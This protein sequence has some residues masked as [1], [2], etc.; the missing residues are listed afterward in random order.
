MKFSCDKS[1]ICEAI[2]NVSK[3]VAVK[4]TMP[5]LEGIKI[6][7]SDNILEL[8][9]YDLEMGMRTQ[10]EVKSDDSGEYVINSRLFSEI[11]KR[12]PDGELLFLIDENLNVRISCG[13]TEYDISAY[14]AD[15]YPDLPTMENEK[16][17]DIPQ[18][19]MKSMINQSVFAVS[20]MD[21]KPVLTGELFD[22]ENGVFNLVAID[23]Y[24]LAIRT[25]KLDCEDKFY[26]VVPSKAMNEVARL[27]KD[28]DEAVCNVFVSDKHIMFDINGYYFFSRLLEGE[29]HNYRISLF[30][31]FKT[32]VIV[33]TRD[34]LDCLERCSLLISEK[35][36]SAIKCK[37]DTSELFIDCKT[38]IG[39]VSDEISIELNGDPVLIAFNNKYL[40]DALKASESDKV[41]IHMN[42]A[43]RPIKILPLQGDSYTFLLMPV[44]IK[45]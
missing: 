44:A 14:S 13:V 21:N 22:I 37:F 36:K 17:F 12:M 31:D 42:G 32:E 20:T 45:A 11:T 34:L 28:D 40:M 1:K 30:S 25:E 10:I 27:L 4:S 35:H 26:F 8:T 15:E 6:K 24:R 38:A 16:H 29:F 33:K 19:I 39:K 43:N 23:G 7:L 5:A 18:G 3:S 9:G 41:R 2:N